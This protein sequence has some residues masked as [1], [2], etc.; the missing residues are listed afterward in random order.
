MKFGPRPAR[1]PHE[2]KD[3]KELPPAKLVTSDE[4]ETELELL[5]FLAK[6]YD[7][8]AQ[9]L[10]ARSSTVAQEL[11]IG[12]RPAKEAPQGDGSSSRPWD[13]LRRSASL[14]VLTWCD[15]RER[16]LAT[17]PDGDGSTGSTGPRSARSPYATAGYCS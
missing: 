5:S 4:A 12:A 9:V 10:P 3:D 1:T 17:S 7:A 16:A 11:T 2:T 6:A 14:S 13:S 15:R 8:S